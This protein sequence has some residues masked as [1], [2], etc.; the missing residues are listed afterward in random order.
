MWKRKRF[1]GG[2]HKAQSMWEMCEKELQ[3]SSGSEEV[4][5]PQ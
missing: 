1:N 3:K 5:K 4:T 2:F